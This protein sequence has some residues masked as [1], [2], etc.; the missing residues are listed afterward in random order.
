MILN[1]NTPVDEYMQ[2]CISFYGKDNIPRTVQEALSKEKPKYFTYK[3]VKKY[4]G[5]NLLEFLTKLQEKTSSVYDPP[6]KRNAIVPFEE[7]AEACG[8]VA[9]GFGKRGTESTIEYTCSSCGGTEKIVTSSTLRKWY[10]TNTKFCPDCR[11]AI[12]SSAGSR[13]AMWQSR[14]DGHV[15]EDFVRVDSM[16]ESNSKHGRLL[17]EFFCCE[18]KKEYNTSVFGAMVQAGKA[19]ACDRC[20]YPVSAIESYVNNELRKHFEDSRIRQ[21]VKYFE[22][23]GERP[24]QD[25]VVDFLIDNKILI[26]VTTVGMSKDKAVYSSNLSNKINWCKENQLKLFV[27]TSVLDIKDIVR[28]ILKSIGEE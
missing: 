4:F 10:N 5:L 16:L 3:S 21:Q 18:Y 13:V 26:E 15:Y 20:S 9:T 8:L 19:F 22:I 25:W 17:L 12:K 28:S 1:E 23:V 11:G 14:L 6:P 27:V 2:Y 24:P 7:Q